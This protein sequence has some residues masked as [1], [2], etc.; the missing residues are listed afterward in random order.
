[1]RLGFL[2]I[3]VVFAFILVA[4]AFVVE[5]RAADFDRPL[6]SGVPEVHIRAA[7][8][9]ADGYTRSVGVRRHDTNELVLCVDLGP[10]EEVVGTTE[11]IVNLGGEVF[12]TAS[13]FDGIGCTGLESGPSADR[14]R[15]KFGPPGIPWML[16]E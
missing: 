14:Q 15:I 3:L 7:A 4:F 2:L 1:M 16:V 12:L 8:V 6:V 13:A 10:E 9:G 5:T 11:A